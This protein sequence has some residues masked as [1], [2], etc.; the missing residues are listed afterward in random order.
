MTVSW[1]NV[2]LDPIYSYGFTGGPGFGTRIVQTD[3]GGEERVSVI[4]EP[5][6]NWSAVRENVGKLSDVIGLRDF[7]LARRG[8]LYGFLF[9]DPI[10]FSTGSGGASLIDGAD[11]TLGYGDAVITSFTMRKTYV[12]PGGMTSRSYARRIIPISQNIT[13][14]MASLIPGTA[15]GDRVDPIVNI[16][17]GGTPV[18]Q[19][20]GTDYSVSASGQIVFATAPAVA[21]TI[22]AGAY[23]TIPARFTGDTDEMF[24]MTAESFGGDS[25]SFGIVSL[26]YDEEVP[27]I[28]GATE[29]GFVE[30]TD[31]IKT[32]DSKESHWYSYTGAVDTTVV[33]PSVGYYPMG[34]PHFRIIND[35]TSE[36]LMTIKD[37]DGDTL[38]TVSI[39][40]VCMIYVRSDGLNPE[41]REALAMKFTKT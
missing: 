28:S 31:T 7:F 16:V 25:A 19:V 11:E 20:E 18:L 12:D 9:F 26:P 21:T 4:A 6:W 32:V 38:I 1:D 34:G 29:Y 2:I 40:E 13:A 17:T 23:F 15:S 30:F 33:L 3:G 22:T 14:A 8:A 39:N 36:A 5:I 10:D 35:G 37:A 41:G 27:V 24:E